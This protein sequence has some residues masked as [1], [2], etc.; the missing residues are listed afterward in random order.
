MLFFSQWT[1]CGQEIRSGSSPPFLRIAY[2]PVCAPSITQ[3]QEHI[4]EPANYHRW[5]S[6]IHGSGCREAMDLSYRYIVFLV[7]KRAFFW[8]FCRSAR[9]TEVPNEESLWFP[10]VLIQFSQFCPDLRSDE[11]WKWMDSKV[12]VV[13]LQQVYIN[14]YIYNIICIFLNIIIVIW[15]YMLSQWTWFS[16]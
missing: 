7:Y 5:A 8:I 16:I 13:T 10:Q 4:Q 6:T 1:V 12:V 11:L 2:S 3:Y 15:Y 9:L 14:I